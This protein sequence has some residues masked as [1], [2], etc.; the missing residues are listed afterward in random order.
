MRAREALGTHILPGRTDLFLLLFADDLALL[1]DSPIGLQNHITCLLDAGAVRKLRLWY[2][3]TGVPSVAE[4]WCI[5]T[6]E[7]EVNRFAQLGSHAL[8]DVARATK[9]LSHDVNA[10]LDVHVHEVCTV[11]EPVHEKGI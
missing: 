2:L 1:S 5:G 9:L 10:A 7:I 11:S 4:K 3:A 6:K 8:Q